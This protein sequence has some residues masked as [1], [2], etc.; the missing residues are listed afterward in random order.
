[1]SKFDE[2]M[3]KIHEE[4]LKQAYEEA[5]KKLIEEK[6]FKGLQKLQEL[7]QNAFS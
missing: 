4:A 3:L 2:T 1:M 7:K 5:E 6:N